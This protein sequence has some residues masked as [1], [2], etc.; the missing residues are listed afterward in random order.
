MLN[1]KVAD[2]FQ[3]STLL[4][5]ASVAAEILLTED[6]NLEQPGHVRLKSHI[7]DKLNQIMLETTL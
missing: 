2:V 1:F 3:D 4:K 6:S 5:D 7:Q